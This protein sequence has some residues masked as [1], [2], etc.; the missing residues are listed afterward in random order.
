MEI[1]KNKMSNQKEFLFYGVFIIIIFLFY[2]FDKNTP[3]IELH[4]ISFFLNYTVSAVI[5][6]YILF[7]KFVYKKK[8]TLFILSLII[9]I[10]LVILIEEL[11]IEKI[12]FPD[13]RG[14]HF[15][16][17]MFTLIDVIPPIIILAGFKLAWEATT[18]QRQ[19]DELNAMVQ[20]S[21]LEFLKSQINPHFLF[22]NLNNLYAH[23]LEKSPKTP[24]IIL[25]LSS[26]L[27]YMLYECK[28]EYVFLEKEIDQL[29]NFIHLGGLQIEGRGSIHFTNEINDTGYQIAPLILMVFVENA[30]K[31]SS[32]SLTE[33]IAVEIC[34]KLDPNGVL[35]FSCK[36]VFQEQSNTESLSNGIGL[37]NVKKRLDL[38][39]PNLYDLAITNANNLYDVQLSIQLK[40]I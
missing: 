33:N 1:Y 30:I 16:N 7:P 28:I 4:E 2:S 25:A 40:R 17:I 15:S 14:K 8:Y 9:V 34:L 5:I 37:T 29:Q 18:K 6:S 27:R 35:F 32:S 21:E 3:L 26:I 22:N 23:A 24:E 19:L 10:T 36:N 20:E 38:V 11:V 31:H 13:T 12:F 39:Y